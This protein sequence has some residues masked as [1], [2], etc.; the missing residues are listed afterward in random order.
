MCTK[1]HEIHNGVKHR[2]AI[3]QDK[4]KKIKIKNEWIKYNPSELI[5]KDYSVKPGIEQRD[6][7]EN[8]LSEIFKGCRPTLRLILSKTMSVF[9][10]SGILAPLVGQLRHCV[11]IATRQTLGKY[12]E[13]ISKE[14]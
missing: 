2:S 9:D 13:E 3:I 6:I 5:L 8:E 12:D 11:R 7:T 10:S 4:P 1:R 14:L